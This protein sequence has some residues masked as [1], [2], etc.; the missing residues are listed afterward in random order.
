[1]IADEKDRA[2]SEQHDCG[3]AILLGPTSWCG[4]GCVCYPP[5]L[6]LVR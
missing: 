4:P 3:P 6:R 1:M 2:W 5:P